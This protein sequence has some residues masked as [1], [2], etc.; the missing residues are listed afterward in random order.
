MLEKKIENYFDR[1][2]P[3]HRSL[4]GPGYNESLEILSEIV[5]FNQL[6][7]PSGQKVFDWTIPKEWNIKDACIKDRHGNRIVDFQASNLHVVSYSVP[8]H[9]HMS[10]S[11]LRPHLHTLPEH[12]D[13]IPFRT[14]YYKEGWGF[15]LSHNQLQMLRDET[16]EVLIDASLENGHLTYGECYLE[17]E[18]KRQ[19]N[20]GVAQQSL[21]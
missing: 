2:W 15:C 19:T 14:S 6:K 1:L 12:P 10:L 13:W 21:V 8:V 20:Y 16:Y 11:E 17:G 18:R 4:S 5:P 7:F 9:R 3:I